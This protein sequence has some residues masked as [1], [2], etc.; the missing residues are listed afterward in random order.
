MHIVFN[1][2]NVGKWENMLL[3]ISAMVCL[4]LTNCAPDS[5]QNADSVGRDKIENPLLTQQGK[6]CA[7]GILFCMNLEEFV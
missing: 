6:P 3:K 2:L 1:K 7:W 4:F 5:R